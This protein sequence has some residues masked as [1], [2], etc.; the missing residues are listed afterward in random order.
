MT[1]EGRIALE[2]VYVAEQIGAFRKLSCM[3]LPDMENVWPFSRLG[4]AGSTCN[5]ERRMLD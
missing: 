4:C 5:V 2:R 1:P 3:V